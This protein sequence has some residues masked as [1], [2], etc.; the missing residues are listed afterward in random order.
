[1]AYHL[2]DILIEAEGF[3]P[4]IHLSSGINEVA[5]ILHGLRIVQT[6]CMQQRHDAVE[7]FNLVDIVRFYT[8]L[9]C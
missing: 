1:M 4:V 2:A 6:S 9:L 3:H 8:R 7:L 5:V